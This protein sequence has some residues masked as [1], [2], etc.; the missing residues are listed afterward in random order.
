MKRL[1]AVL[2]MG[3]ILLWATTALAQYSALEDDP[4]Y[5]PYV[6]I[7]GLVIFGDNGSA[8]SDSE[9]LA[10]LNLG[11]LTDYLAYQIFYGMGEE[12]TAWGGSIDYILA[13]NF[14]ECFTC[15]EEGKWWFGVGGT[16][17]DI[18]DLYYDEND[19]SAALA[20]TFY[21]PNLGFGYMWGDWTLNL[22]GHYMIN[23]E[24]QFGLQGSVM[25][26]IAN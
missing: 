7:G 17:V 11:G 22:F 18:D 21:G 16:F 20:D 6:G 8:E 26:N 3:A 5:G 25:Y 2:V 14:D 10:T 13:S 24:D 12:S 15:P 19:A 4:V 23:D 9:F 1:I